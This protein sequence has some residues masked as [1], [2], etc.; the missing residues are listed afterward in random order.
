MRDQYAFICGG[1]KGYFYSYA[2]SFYLILG[3]LGPRREFFLR[4]GIPL[5]ITF[6]FR[7]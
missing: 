2:C 3:G 1:G 5:A 6:Y 7:G 4:G